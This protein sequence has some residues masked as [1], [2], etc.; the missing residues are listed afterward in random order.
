MTWLQHCCTLFGAELQRF[1]LYLFILAYSYSH[2]YPCRIASMAT[3]CHIAS[4]FG[5]LLTWL[6]KTLGSFTKQRNAYGSGWS[7]GMSSAIFSLVI[8]KKN[9]YIYIHVPNL[10]LI[11]SLVLFWEEGNVVNK[12]SQG[13]QWSPRVAVCQWT[14]L[15]VLTRCKRIVPSPKPS[16][17]S[18]LILADK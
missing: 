13:C 7:F 5:K 10:V 6:R 15:V 2:F 18:W 17:V 4:G 12:M 14:D 1:H 9:I 16:R 8:S 11:V 3:L